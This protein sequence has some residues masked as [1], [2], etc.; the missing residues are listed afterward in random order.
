M[1]LSP[2][3]FFL[4]IHLSTAAT[5]SGS[6]GGSC[7]LSAP[8]VRFPFGLTGGS[9]GEHINSTNPRCSF[10]GFALSY[11]GDGQTTIVLQNSGEFVVQYIEYHS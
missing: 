11:D 8:N 9:G 2:P 10:P 6:C 3:L 1:L 5:G 7:C 4:L